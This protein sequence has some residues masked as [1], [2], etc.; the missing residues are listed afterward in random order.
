M[1]YLAYTG[2]NSMPL[3]IGDSVGEAIIDATIRITRL[4]WHVYNYSL[5]TR[6]LDLTKDEVDAIKKAFKETERAMFKN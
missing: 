3:G 1:V 5:I 2:E 6:S 4:G